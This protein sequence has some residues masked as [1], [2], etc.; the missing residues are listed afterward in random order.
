M[1]TPAKT[2]CDPLAPQTSAAASAASLEVKLTNAEEE[3]ETGTMDLIALRCASGI[4]ARIAS[5]A[6]LGGREVRKKET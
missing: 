3:V 4:C 6:V 2:S 1:S 5:S